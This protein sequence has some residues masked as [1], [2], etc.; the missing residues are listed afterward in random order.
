MIF[1]VKYV[2]FLDNGNI[3]YEKLYYKIEASQRYSLD[4]HADKY[5]R[6]HLN[7]PHYKFLSIRVAHDDLVDKCEIIKLTEKDQKHF[8]EYSN[9]FNDWHKEG[10]NKSKG[11]EI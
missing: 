10:L 5:I 3:K 7:Y 1:E 8:E 9:R 6:E 2:V 11:K 4:F